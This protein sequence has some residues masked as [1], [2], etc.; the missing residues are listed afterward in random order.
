[1]PTTKCIYKDITFIVSG[2]LRYKCMKCIKIKCSGWKCWCESSDGTSKTQP[3]L[4]R[5]L[6]MIMGQI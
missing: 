3:S 4:P 5:L 6:S 2:R 1:M